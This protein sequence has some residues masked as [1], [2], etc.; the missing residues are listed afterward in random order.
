MQ[1][2]KTNSQW[3]IRNLNF[4]GCNQMVGE[5]KKKMVALAAEAAVESKGEKEN[6]GTGGGLWILSDVF[7]VQAGT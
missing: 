4:D 1:D 5:A 6:G 2:I 7:M 3:R